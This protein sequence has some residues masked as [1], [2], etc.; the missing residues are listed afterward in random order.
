MISKF[1]TGL[2]ATLSVVFLFAGMAFGKTKQI[3]VF[4][5]SIVGHSLRLAPG[6][7]RINVTEN[8]AKPEVRFYSRNGHLVGQVPARMVSH[9]QKNRHT[10]ID[11]D[12][13]ASNQEVLT[14]ISPK[15][16]REKLIFSHPK[17]N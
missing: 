13:V 14:E 5:R 2:I 7:Y 17:T 15:G 10:V 1:Q 11:Y 6:P 12:K 8:T 16:W 9:A 3:N 4:Y